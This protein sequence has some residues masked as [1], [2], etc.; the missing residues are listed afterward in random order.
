MAVTTVH[1]KGKNDAKSGKET[2]WKVNAVNLDASKY[3]DLTKGSVKRKGAEVDVP[4]VELLGSNVSA[5][6]FS[7]LDD[8]R[9]DAGD[10][11]DAAVLEMINE[12][13]ETRA[14]KAAKAFVRGMLS[15]DGSTITFDGTNVDIWT[16]EGAEG[17]AKTG[18]VSAKNQAA[19]ALERA[20]AIEDPNE[21][22]A[23]LMAAL[24]AIAG[25]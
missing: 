17:P 9:T 16:V 23:Q 18:R 19:Q 20:D 5:K 14:E 1:L 6:K 15:Y 12:R 11:F 2:P 25:K 21:R 8:A 24:A 7:T 10:R 13:S 4:Q 22:I 3:P